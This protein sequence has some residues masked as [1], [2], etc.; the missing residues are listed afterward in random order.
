MDDPGFDRLL[1]PYPDD[2]NH[3]SLSNEIQTNSSYVNHR[4][5]RILIG[6]ICVIT[7]FILLTFGTKKFLS[8]MGNKNKPSEQYSHVETKVA[9]STLPSKGQRKYFKFS[10]RIK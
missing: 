3:S 2:L 10:S 8:N 9:E 1:V 4:I 6:C 7:F 5:R